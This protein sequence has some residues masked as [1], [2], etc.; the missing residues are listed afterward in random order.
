MPEYL[1]DTGVLILCLRGDETTLALWDTLAATGPLHISA[2]THLE[3]IAGM[4]PWEEDLTRDILTSCVCHPLDEI[5]GDK[6]GRLI[7]RYRSQ[8]VALSVPDA[9]IAATALLSGLTL[10]TRNRKHFP[11]PELAIYPI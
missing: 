2:V 7:A 9:A 8:G 3:I 1:C 10:V 4:Q 6:A 5:I 11:M